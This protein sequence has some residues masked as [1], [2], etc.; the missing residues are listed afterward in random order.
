MFNFSDNIRRCRVAA[1]LTQQ[2]VA[3]FLGLDRSTYCYYESG[4]I[5]PDVKT[6]FDLSKMFGVNYDEL[7]DSETSGNLAFADES[8]DFDDN[9]SQAT[10]HVNNQFADDLVDTGHSI[11]EYMKRKDCDDIICEQSCDVNTYKL[12]FDCQSNFE[13]LDKDQD[14][15][16]VLS[17]DEQRLVLAFRGLSTKSKQAVLDIINSEIDLHLDSFK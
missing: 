1:G 10:K 16:E 2:Q 7:L 17:E 14:C 3:E 4:R 5:H 15:D 8:F 12:H 13:T 9:E 11:S 6:L